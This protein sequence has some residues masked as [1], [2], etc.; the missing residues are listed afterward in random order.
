VIRSLAFSAATA[1]ILLLAAMPQ[2]VAQ[3]GALPVDRN[4][5]EVRDAQKRCTEELKLQLFKE[6]VR[7]TIFGAEEEAFQRC[8]QITG[9]QSPQ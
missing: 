1:V 9:W 2:S 8:K 7:K 5:Q 4:S 3:E 6:K